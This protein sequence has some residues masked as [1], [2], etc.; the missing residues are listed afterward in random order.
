MG[1]L[2]LTKAYKRHFTASV[3][4]QLIPIEKVLYLTIKGQGDP[5]GEGF[6]AAIRALYSVAYVIKFDN[7]AR[8]K[9]F[10]VS[11]LEGFWWVEV[12]GVDPLSVPRHLWCYELAILL[13]DDISH[14]QYELAVATAIAKKKSPLAEQVQLREVN[15]E[16][17][18]QIL[19]EGPFSKEPETLEKLHGYIAQE[20]LT[21]NGWHHEIYLSDFRKTAPE[22][23]KTILR[24]PVK[25]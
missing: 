20:G 4:P 5:D 11:K 8:G 15:E 18:V 3:H 2:D 22:K 13:P 19:H 23:L 9:D 6:A 14:A 24:Q 25:K 7:K 12:T 1:K 10:V 16:L 21:F 17:C